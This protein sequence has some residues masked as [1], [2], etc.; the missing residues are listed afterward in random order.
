MNSFS[1]KELPRRSQS[2]FF[3]DGV[4]LSDAGMRQI[5]SITMEQQMTQR[6]KRTAKRVA[7]LLPN[8]LMPVQDK[9]ARFA[10]TIESVVSGTEGKVL[11]F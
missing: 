10:A 5:K 2:P 1:F 6:K 4:C 11:Y 8:P 7:S 9:E 3:V